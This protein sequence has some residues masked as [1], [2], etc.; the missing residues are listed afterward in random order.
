MSS[1]GDQVKHVAEANYYFFGG[2]DMT[3]AKE[4][5]KSEEIEKLTTKADIMQALRESFKQAHA[6]VD[7]ITAE[8]AFQTTRTG[9]G[10]VWP[11]SDWRT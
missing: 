2:P 8:N 1:F 11:H 3:D 9:P 7:G 5:A 4:K 6:L 10:P